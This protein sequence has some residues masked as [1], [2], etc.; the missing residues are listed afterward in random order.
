[1]DSRVALK[2]DEIESTELYHLLVS[3]MIFISYYQ[4]RMSLF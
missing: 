1:M 3:F 4:Q 2:A